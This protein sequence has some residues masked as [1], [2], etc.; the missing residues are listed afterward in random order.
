MIVVNEYSS[1]ILS[2][3]SWQLRKGHKI[4]HTRL[5]MPYSLHIVV[6]EDTLEEYEQVNFVVLPVGQR[7]VKNDN[8]E[9]VALAK[10]IS[11]QRFKKNILGDHVATI[12]SGVTYN[13]FYLRCKDE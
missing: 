10:R 2:D 13:I 7:F 9:Q 11:N 4:L 6:L 3:V 12:H 1:S 8:G 5:Q